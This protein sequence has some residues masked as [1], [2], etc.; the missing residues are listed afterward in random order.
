MAYSCYL[1][2]VP[3]LDLLLSA[4]VFWSIGVRRQ[5]GLCF[6][7]YSYTREQ[8]TFDLATFHFLYLVATFSW[9][10][11][12]SFLCVGPCRFMSSDVHTFLVKVICRYFLMHRLFLIFYYWSWKTSSQ[13]EP[14]P[15]GAALSH[16]V[17]IFTIVH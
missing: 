15:Y 17:C 3:F 5:L 11:A 1:P 4:V 10:I 14:K 8:H 12:S 9:M 2:P 16:H 6:P 7:Q 13:K